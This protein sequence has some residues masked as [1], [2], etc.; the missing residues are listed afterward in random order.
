MI[1][2]DTN[3]VSQLIRRNGSEMVRKWMRDHADDLWTTTITLSELAYGVELIADYEQR[4]AMMNAVAAFRQQF[5]R[6]ILAFD[7]AAADVHGWLQAR[8]KKQTGSRLPEL[9]AQIA[10]IAISRSASVATRNV[11]DFEPTGVTILNPW[12]I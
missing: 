2:A 3:V 11:R 12:E 6:S 1:V 8:A 7:V 4:I 10:S 5:D 9:D